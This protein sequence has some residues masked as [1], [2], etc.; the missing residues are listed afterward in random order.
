MAANVE[1]M[2]YVRETPWHGLGTKVQEA[3]DSKEALRLA[4]LD[5]KVLQEPIRT[6]QGEAVPGYKANVRDV[7]RKDEIYASAYEIDCT[8]RIYEKLIEL[9][10][11]LEIG[12]LQ[13]CM[14]ICSL[15]SFLYEQWLKSDT[16]EL[17]EVIERSLMESIAKVA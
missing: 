14:K 8:I 6:A 11:R 4:G 2:F 1:S 12:Q 15:L 7:D 16:G 17:E 5:W 10:E 9:C 3:P 13:E